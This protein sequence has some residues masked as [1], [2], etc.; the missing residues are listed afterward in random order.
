MGSYTEQNNPWLAA[1][2]DPYSDLEDIWTRYLEGDRSNMEKEILA[3]LDSQGIRIRLDDG[4]L[5]QLTVSKPTSVTSGFVIGLRYTKRD[6]TQTEDHF[7][8]EKGHPIQRHYKGTLECKWPDYRGTHKQ[9]VT[10]TLV[11][12][13]QAPITSVNTIS[14]VKDKE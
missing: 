13:E 6:G 3:L 4:E 11:A 7:S 9:Q 10:F 14:L 12:D 8:V 1:M 2:N 5:K